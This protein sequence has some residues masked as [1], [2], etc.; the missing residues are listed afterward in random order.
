MR[1]EQDRVETITSVL[2][3]ELR[4]RDITVNAVAPGLEH[5]DTP[6][7]IANVV[8]FLVSEEGHAI[9]GQVIRIA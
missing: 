2:A 1:G 3:R 7:D 5:A 4:G 6:T 8:A 9:S